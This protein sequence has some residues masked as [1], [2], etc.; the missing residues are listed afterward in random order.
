MSEN[1]IS[2]VTRQNIADETVLNKLYYE[3]RSTEPDF[4]SRLFELK[5]LP[6]RDPMRRYSN[7]YDDIYQHTVNNNDYSDNWIYSDPRIDLLH[8]ADELYLKFLTETLH[9]MVRNE[10]EEISKL[11]EIYNRH[12]IADGF[13]I[14]QDGDISGRPLFSWH[15][16]N[17]G[18]A[19]FVSKKQEIKKYLD[20]KYVNKKLEL[21]NDAL[22]K[23]N[24]DIAIGTA[25]E[26]LETTC[27]SILKYR[28]VVIDTDWSL[29]QIIKKTS[30]NL[31]VLPKDVDNANNAEK[32][33]K[34]I[35]GGISSIVHGVAELRNSYGTGHGKNAD[36]K[37]LETSYAKL[38][39][40][41]VYD[42]ASFYLAINGETAELVE[43]Q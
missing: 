15:E 36:F 20:T 37:G 43:G 9:P 16:K 21:I 27:K 39:V 22:K 26:L 33:V 38:L 28:N 17:I 12:L 7:A 18:E 40:G 10:I 31:D 23:E 29:P 6:S 32:S 13:E 5:K 1:K 35:I 8:C 25:K 41:V 4:L 19:S 14:L 34:Q 30:E 3:G 42:I 24:T 11:L 2:E